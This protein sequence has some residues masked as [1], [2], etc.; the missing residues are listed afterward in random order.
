MAPPPA[1]L[2]QDLE[3]PAKRPKKKK[4][5]AGAAVSSTAAPAGPP[6]K[7]RPKK[8]TGLQQEASVSDRHSG[9]SAGDN[10]AML[11]D[12]ADVLAQVDQQSSAHRATEETEAT[13]H[14]VPEVPDE[15]TRRWLGEMIT[16]VYKRRNPAKVQEIPALLE[17]YANMEWDLY[18]RICEKYN[19]TTQEQP[20]FFTSEAPADRAPRSGPAEEPREVARMESG[21]RHEDDRLKA[22]PPPKGSDATAPPPKGFAKKAGP[23]TKP[24]PLAIV[25]EQEVTPEKPPGEQP[26]RAGSESSSSASDSDSEADVPQTAG[27]TISA[28]SGTGPRFG[29]GILGGLPL[30]GSA[31]AAKVA[32]DM[33]QA[34]SLHVAPVAGSDL[35]T[36]HD[37]VAEDDHL[38][39]RFCAIF[40]ET[41]RNTGQPPEELRNSGRST[42]RTSEGEEHRPGPPP[43]QWGEPGGGQQTR[44][45]ARPPMAVDPMG[46]RPPVLGL[47]PPMLG[48]PL[49]PP[50]LGYSWP[51][52]SFMPMPPMLAPHHQAAPRPMPWGARP[53]MQA[54]ALPLGDAW[55]L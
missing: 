22:P 20:T 26:H 52:H 1:Q 50:Q 15:L 32:A 14:V 10:A 38:L 41:T 29:G 24:P 39:S 23:P 30:L 49:P 7:R 48:H 46:G 42:T 27:A 51:R 40:G 25:R 3:P 6:K 18:M 16:A 53:P 19:E 54:V 4:R 28:S 36:G 21:G 2:H 34:P 47:P 33:N 11:L 35:K 8:A 43:G 5:E 37:V 45:G 12:A 31:A 55:M 13:H 44:S 17:K 9:H